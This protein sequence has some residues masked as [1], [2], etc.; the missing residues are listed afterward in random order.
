MRRLFKELDKKSHVLRMRLRCLHVKCAFGHVNAAQQAFATHDERAHNA[1]C[2]PAH[3]LPS[4]TAMLALLLAAPS[5][6]P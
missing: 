6:K 1:A 3:P 4:H 2:P 5:P